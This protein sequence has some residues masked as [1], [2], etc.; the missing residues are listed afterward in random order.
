VRIGVLA[1][2]GDVREHATLLE[3]LG[4]DVVRITVPD[5]LDGV[6]GLVLPGGEST[7]ISMLLDSSGL[8]PEL[9][10]WINDD[11][12]TLGTCA[13]LVLL[14][15]TVLDGRID[16]EG[17]GGLEITVRRNGYGR[18]K[19][20]FEASVEAPRLGAT[21][22]AVFIRAP[23]IVEIGDDV[24]VVARLGADG[25]AVAVAQGARLGCAFH[26]ELSGDPRLHERL[27]NLARSAR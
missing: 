1:L 6:D 3:G 14:A 9:A 2:Q 8:R 12:P 10:K 27:V 4:V 17:L 13:G 19:S 20:S 25:E 5:D 23:R 22:D 15:E 21:F 26:P 18:Q 24:E 7:T 11:R 16:Q